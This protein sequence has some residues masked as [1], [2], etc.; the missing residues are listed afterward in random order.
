MVTSGKSSTEAR[1]LRK[2]YESR[3]PTSG[4]STFYTC[5]KVMGKTKT[6]CGQ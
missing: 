5:P 4:G 6:G 1:L 3:L 2:S